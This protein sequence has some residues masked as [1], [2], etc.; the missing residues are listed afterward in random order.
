MS[1]HC[2]QKVRRLVAAGIGE[3]GLRAGS[4]ELRY[5]VGEGLGVLTFVE[6]VGGE[7]E[8]EGSD[9]LD[10]RRAPVEEGRIRLPTQVG[11]GVV[12]REVEG[13]LVMVRRQYCRAA[14]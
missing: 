8:V 11:A 10:V 13:R 14:G 4:E 3:D 5:Q 6:D 12:G 1:L 7:Y 9:T 2:L